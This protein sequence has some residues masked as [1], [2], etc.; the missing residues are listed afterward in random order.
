MSNS[1]GCQEY[2]QL[3]FVNLACQIIVVCTRALAS[4]FALLIVT[5]VHGHA[6]YAKNIELI[7]GAKQVEDSS[8]H[9]KINKSK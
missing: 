2:D 3:P 7:L 5:M 1:L 9:L 4:I 6:V 8:I